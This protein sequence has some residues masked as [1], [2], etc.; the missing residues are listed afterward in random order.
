MDKMTCFLPCRK[1][2]QRVPDKNVKRFAGH[3][4]GLIQ[5][6]LNQLL[7]VRSLDE[8]VLS[9]N[10]ER[11]LEYAASLRDSRIRLH[12]RSE[13]LSSSSASTDWLVGHALDL[14]PEGHILW[15]HVTSPFVTAKQYES[16]LGEYRSKLMDGFDSLMT[17]TEIYGFLWRDG[18]PMNYDRSQEK[19]PRTQTLKPIHEVN[20]AVFLAPVEVYR[21]CRDR[22]G[23]TPY[24]YP[25]DKLVSHDIDWPEDFVIAE[26]MAERGLVEL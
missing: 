12:H 19:W 11:I 23:E 21:N 7:S 4:H 18:R 8:I 6:K 9:S 25:L 15:T 1:G 2:S 20:S 26:C 24:L 16:I 17:T 10:D 22:I 5:V 13:E 3:D 14:I